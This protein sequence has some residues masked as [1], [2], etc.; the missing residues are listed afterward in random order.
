MAARQSTLAPSPTGN[1]VDDG[2]E[3]EIRKETENET[4]AAGNES[5]L[6]MNLQKVGLFILLMVFTKDDW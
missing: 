2:V 6:D 1:A 5:P 4:D 3:G